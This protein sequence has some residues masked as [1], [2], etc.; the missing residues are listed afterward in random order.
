MHSVLNAHTV[1]AVL[2]QLGV[3]RKGA[4]DEFDS[5]KLGWYG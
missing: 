3:Y 5:V 4:P 1:N 2:K